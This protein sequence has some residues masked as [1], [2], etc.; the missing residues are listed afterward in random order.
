MINVVYDIPHFKYIGLGIFDLLGKP[1][2]PV[3]NKPTTLKNHQFDVS[4]F[5]N[6]LYFVKL[7][8]ETGSVV[9]PF[10]LLKN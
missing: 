5:E 1:L 6:G 10:V 7:S 2:L 3:I 9:K 4:A 8:S